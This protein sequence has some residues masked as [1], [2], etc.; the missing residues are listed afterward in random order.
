MTAD[1]IL[2]SKT[3]SMSSHTNGENFFSIRQAVAEEKTRVLCG[4]TDRQT[5][6]Q[7]NGPKCNTLSFGEGNKHT[8]THSAKGPVTP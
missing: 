4:Q 3:L 6:R 7:T 2:I 1:V 5:D 8:H